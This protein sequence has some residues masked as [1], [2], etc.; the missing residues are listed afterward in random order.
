MR[1]QMTPHLTTRWRKRTPSGSSS[2]EGAD[3][4]ERI[5]SARERVGSI[6]ALHC[7]RNDPR[8][9]SDAASRE[10]NA[11]AG[12]SRCPASSKKSQGFTA[13]PRSE[14]A[15]KCAC[16]ECCTQH[17]PLILKPRSASG[18]FFWGRHA[19]GISCDYPH[20]RTEGIL[21]CVPSVADIGVMVPERG[22]DH[23]VAFSAYPTLR[24]QEGRRAG[25]HLA[26]L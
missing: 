3:G 15:I 2:R 14:C 22:R 17:E 11:C 24:D 9:V 23:A 26:A 8:R 12:R 13:G 16:A 25:D 7:L 19:K 18:A 20:H 21:G 10:V 6:F 1:R 4:P 5:S